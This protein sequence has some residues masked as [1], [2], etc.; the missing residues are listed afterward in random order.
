MTDITARLADLQS[1]VAT[2]CTQCGRDPSEVRLLAVSKTKPLDLIEDAIA[3][4]QDDFGENYLQ[5]AL[6]KTEAL[7]KATWHFIGAIQSNKTRDI[8]NHFD[9]VHSVA[10]EKVAR[11]LSEQR[12]PALGP[13]KVLIQVNTSQESQKSGVAPEQ[14]L[15]LAKYLANLDNLVAAGLMTIPAA[16]EDPSQQRRPFQMLR[17]TRDHIVDTAGLPDFQHL[18]MGMTGDFETAITEGSTWIRIGTAI[19][20]SRS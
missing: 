12:D 2:A 20:G 10:S 7:P 9:W 17:E 18:S 13:L 8:A 19:F 4:G 14:A 1:R 11:R 5:D 6:P 16:S 3:A 15:P